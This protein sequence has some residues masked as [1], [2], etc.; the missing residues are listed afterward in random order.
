MLELLVAALVVLLVSPVLM[1]MVGF[2]FFLR[3]FGRFTDEV[4]ERE[5]RD[6]GEVE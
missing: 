6:E 5:A 1:G 3:W 4:L 2:V